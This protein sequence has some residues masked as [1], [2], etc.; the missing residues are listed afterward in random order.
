MNFPLAVDQ[1]NPL[2]SLHAPYSIECPVFCIPGA[3]ASVTSFV[4]FINALDGKRPIYGLQ[5]RGIDIAEQ[6]YKSVE[7][8]ALYN[9]QALTRCNLTRPIHL[10]GHSYGGLVA[11]E[12]ALRLHEQGRRVASLTLIDTD[13]PDSIEEAPHQFSTAEIFGEFKEAFEDTFEKSLDIDQAVI[14]S[15]QAEVFVNEL[16]AALIKARVL[17]S[18]NNIAMLRGSLATFAAAYNRRYIPDRCYANTLHLVL[19]GPRSN[20]RVSMDDVRMKWELHAIKWWRWAAAVDIWHGPGHHFSILR[21]P[22]VY[23]LAKWWQQATALSRSNSELPK[24]T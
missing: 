11:F 1:F 9:L 12:M 8:A 16:N 20:K 13:P 18:R 4:E 3:G 22:Q 10:L 15:G 5:P 2:V 6:P 17:P 23:S 14:A 7:D 19:V 21:A 24:Q